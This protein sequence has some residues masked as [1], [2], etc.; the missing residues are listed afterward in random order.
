MQRD[1]LYNRSTRPLLERSTNKNQAQPQ[2]KKKSSADFKV[3]GFNDFN[4]VA[5][6][7]K[8]LN[9]HIIGYPYGSPPP[10]PTIINIDDD[11]ERSHMDG[12][13][14]DFLF[15][16][17]S[18]INVN[19]TSNLSSLASSTTNY[20]EDINSSYEPSPQV[21]A[22]NRNDGFLSGW[23]VGGKQQSQQ[24]QQKPQKKKNI[25]NDFSWQSP[26]QQQQ[27]QKKPTKKVQPVVRTPP[28]NQFNSNGPFIFGVHTNG[29][30]T[31]P[32]I[33]NESVI[34]ST[35]TYASIDTT[36]KTDDV[37]EFYVLRFI[38]INYYI[39]DT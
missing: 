14:T 1:H 10:S 5:N 23:E 21:P 39:L 12:N 24:Q 13:Q 19:N 4:F 8:N 18:G 30:Y 2:V 33:N 22:R 3:H 38:L 37:S 20:Y 17:D 31:Q 9:T 27:Q 28:I 11:P 29:C 7:Y 35:T 16:D 25:G 26:K 32:K 34:N 15:S 6:Q 36:N